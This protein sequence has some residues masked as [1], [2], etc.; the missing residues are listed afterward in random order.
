LILYGSETQQA[1][2]DA[3]ELSALDAADEDK[4]LPEAEFLDDKIKQFLTLFQEERE[5]KIS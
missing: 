1:S 3:A 4:R 5:Q 2:V